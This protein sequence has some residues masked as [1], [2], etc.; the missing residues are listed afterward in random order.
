MQ[1]DTD[2]VFANSERLLKGVIRVSS[3]EV[4]QQKFR[5]CE[6]AGVVVEVLSMASN[7]SLLEISR[8]PNPFLHV[9]ALQQVLSFGDKF[10]GS[11]LDVLIE[12]VASKNLLSV[13]VV[14]H[15]RVQERVAEHCLSYE[16]VVLIVEENVIVVQEQEGGHG[17][18]HHVLLVGWVINV[19]VGHVIIPLW[20]VWVQEHG[21]EWELWPDSLHDVEEIHHLLDTLVSLL[22]HGSV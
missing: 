13:L 6:I 20:V 11:H 7:K 21:L 3:D 9:V 1:S 4:L 19:Q 5:V 16:L 18:V 17:Q 12:E 10:V 2:F 15:L 14:K 22:S 8:P